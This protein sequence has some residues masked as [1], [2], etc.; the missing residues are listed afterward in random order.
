MPVG[1]LLGIVVAMGMV[2]IFVG[3]PLAVH[4]IDIV[5]EFWR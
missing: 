4:W 3:V 5:V 1:L 2:A